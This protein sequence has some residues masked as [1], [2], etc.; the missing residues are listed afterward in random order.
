ML[1]K[2][3]LIA[4]LILSII[5]LFRALPALLKRKNNASITKHLGKRMFFSGLILLLLFI[6]LITGQIEPNLPPF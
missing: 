2:W 6:A 3:I 4:L 1:L 5:N